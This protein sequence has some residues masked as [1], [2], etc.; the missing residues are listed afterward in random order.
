MKKKGLASIVAI[1]MVATLIM[2][3]FAASMPFA[4]VPKDHWAYDS[5]A[6]LAASGLI[7]GYPDGT[8]KGERQFT[9]YEMAMVFARVLGR[10]DTLIAAEVGA[11]VKAGV[12]GLSDEIYDKVAQALVEEMAKVKAELTATI[13][14][15]LANVELPEAK[16]VERVV[17][18]K[19]V[20]VVQPFEL[21]DEAK[22]IIAKVAA[23]AVAE[24]VSKLEPK[25]VEKLVELEPEVT[26]KELQELMAAVANAQMTADLTAED[27]AALKADVAAARDLLD[28][29]AF[30]LDVN[31]AVLAVTDKKAEMALAEADGAL[32][33]AEEAKAKAAT[34]T[35]Q[36]LAALKGAEDAGAAAAAAAAKADA[37]TAAAEAATQE[38]RNLAITVAALEGDVEAL[39]AL[40]E[41]T[42][43]A[44]ESEI[45]ALSEEFGAELASL[46]VR[47]AD[48]ENI[49]ADHTARIDALEGDVRKLEEDAATTAS[50]VVALRAADQILAED[51][52]TLEDEHAATAEKLTVVDEEQKTTATDFATF[53]AEHEK[54]KLSG[55]TETVFE[56]IGIEGSAIAGEGGG[57]V[58]RDPRDPDNDDEDDDYLYEKTAKLEQKFALNLEATPAEGVSVTAT[59]ADAADIFGD[60]NRKID[61]EWSWKSLKLEVTTD[62]AL[63]SFFAGGMERPDLAARYN[64]FIIDDDEDLDDTEVV[65]ANVVL[66]NLDTQVQLFRPWEADKDENAPEAG[67][68]DYRWAGHKANYGALVN[69]AYKLSDA[70]VI[71]LQYGRMWYDLTADT[72]ETGLKDPVEDWAYSLGLRG[73]L[74]F[75]D[76][77]VAY[78]ANQD[79]KTGYKVV[80]GKQYGEE[81]GPEWKVTYKAVDDGYETYLAGAI[82]AYTSELKL[83]ADDF[84]VFGVTL[85]A[86]YTN[87]EANTNKAEPKTDVTAMKFTAEKKDLFGMP[88]TIGGRYANIDNATVK[89][90]SS[91][92]G[93]VAYEPTFGKLKLGASY[94]YT[95]NAID[96]A[97]DNP[98]KWIGAK[99]KVKDVDRF[100]EEVVEATT[101][102]SAE[103]PV[104]IWDTTI[105]GFVGYE[106]RTSDVKERYGREYVDPLMTYRVS[107]ERDFGEANVLASY[108][109]RTGG[110]NNP[111]K[112]I[113][114]NVTPGADPEIDKITEVKLT[115]PVAEVADLVLG[116]RFVDVE[117]W[118]TEYNYKAT[119]LNAGLKF[120]F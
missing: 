80:V 97:F 17:V 88:I 110:P 62:K 118:E 86:A 12:A 76:Y 119:E 84:E 66:G 46:G 1:I 116:Y 87:K 114:G 106:N 100:G 30:G 33:A 65:A 93:K 3:A 24:N 35:E 71:D 59:L 109:Y 90:G 102:L 99:W 92:M 31:D 20:E 27:V 19:P 49:V 105:K 70:F 34:A 120:E 61:Q 107:A 36:A 89:E 45:A 37:A 50:D 63:R 101:K 74:N 81:D 11:E 2:P 78:A 91:L 104:E 108:Q 54:V 4:D 96:G 43:R 44:M 58:Y 6:E 77:E 73:E 7:I 28:E 9:R 51:L 117:A 94:E 55:S 52:S 47:V 95:T 40:L 39:A 14:S 60:T 64:E 82:D 29:V 5:V 111:D 26:A 23:D 113:D 16:V 115:Y 68:P 13:E 32:E 72:G 8:F 98:D 67:E 22:A 48:L 25:V 79:E 38:V 21:T 15:E 85:G 103:Y 83:S 57:K 42:S 18:E 112:E 41:N 10:L 75:A 56:N 69:S 53:K